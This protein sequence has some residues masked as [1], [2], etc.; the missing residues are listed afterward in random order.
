[1]AYIAS[2]RFSQLG[3]VTRPDPLLELKRYAERT[4]TR[5]NFLA[6]P[7]I[8]PS[9]RELFISPYPPGYN[10]RHR[11]E[12]K[13]VED[14]MHALLEF[15]PRFTNLRKLV[16]HFPYCNE[17][18]FA[19]LASLKLD[20]FELELQPT[21]EGE[22]PI[23]ARREFR[24]A[25]NTSPIQCFPSDAVS[26]RFLFPECLQR[27]VA[28]PTGTDIIARAL[29]SS[30]LPALISLDIAL[31]FVA[32]PHFFSALAACPALAA[33]RLR[34]SALDGPIP[35]TLP[36]SLP[37]QSHTS[38][39]TTARPASSPPSRATAP[40]APR[41]SGPPT[42]CP[43]SHLE[44][45]VTF[46]PPALLDALA[47]AVPNLRSLSVNAHLDAFHPGTVERKSLVLEAPVRARLRLSSVDESMSTSTG[48]PVPWDSRVG[49][50]LQT[51]R[52]GAQLVGGTPAELAE[53]AREVV[54]GFPEAYD[55]TSWQRWIVD[56]PW[57]CVEWTHL[58]N[59]EKNI[60]FGSEAQYPALDANHASAPVGDVDQAQKPEE[61]IPG[62][63]G[64]VEGTLRIEYGEHY[65]QS[66]ER[67]ARIS[68]RTVD[69]AIS[70][71]G[72]PPSVLN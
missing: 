39:R 34:S 35:T 6:G 18:V 53:N 50:H 36:P 11:V 17:Q 43:S 47:S 28:G 30:C 46:V 65:F 51:L 70:R 60:Y 10:R 32:S 27:I 31:R 12:H 64:D 15:L 7:E 54:E 68:A 67:G 41:A 56:R 69:E 14:V 33:L 9:V 1:M 40:C 24:F 52:L 8:S 3:S 55:P 44:I 4:L 42:A 57:Y 5:L 23:P 62:I 25:P 22:I 20:Y 72:V 13:P 29:S 16:L 71:I 63:G 2:I 61:D 38:Q 59:D 45:G 48:L 58:S 21:S 26:L 37:L 49:L 19:S 66:F